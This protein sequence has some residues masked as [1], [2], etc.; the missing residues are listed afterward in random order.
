MN[1]KSIG[2]ILIHRRATLYSKLHS[3]MQN[4]TSNCCSHHHVDRH[5]L[6]SLCALHFVSKILARAMSHVVPFQGVKCLNENLKFLPRKANYT[7][8]M[9]SMTSF[10]LM[11]QITPP[12]L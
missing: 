8:L 1:D 4:L 9:A 11:Q 12:V 5:Y 7:M 10:T 6:G 3:Y 2:V